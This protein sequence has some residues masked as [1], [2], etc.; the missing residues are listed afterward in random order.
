MAAKSL[1]VEFDERKIDAIFSQVDQCHK[2]GAAVGIAIDGKP[3]Y[4][5]GFGLANMELPIVLSPSIRM[6]IYSMTKHFA[7]LA[8]M[9]LCEDGKAG[10]DDAIGKHVVGL[11]PAS[12]NATVLQLMGHTS[13]IRDAN[14][15]CWQFNGT[16]LPA[17]SAD[18]VALYRDINDV[19]TPAG[20][21]WIYNIGGYLLLTAAIE[22]IAGKRFE[23]VLRE[24]I[25]EP[26]GMFNTMLRRRDID[27]I[28]NSAT[29]HM[30]TM[31][32]AYVKSY[33]GNMAGEG[34]I[35]STVDDMLR[36]LKHMDAPVVGTAETWKLMKAPHV[37]ANGTSTG[38]GLGLWA[39]KYRGA[40]QVRHGGVGMGANSQMIKLPGAALDIVVMVNGHDLSAFTFGNHIIDACVSGLEPVKEE[41][42][43][44]LL[45]GVYVSKKTG[46]VVRLSPAER[47]T[48]VIKEGQQIATVDGIDIP[49]VISDDG[50]LHPTA[51]L[52]PSSR[53]LVTPMGGG[54][55]PGSLRLNEF[56]NIDEFVRQKASVQPDP[57][58]FAGRYAH[59]AT[60]TEA[61]IYDT[62]NSVRLKT[63]GRFGATELELECLAEGYWR[64]KA[65]T[66]MPWGGTLSF[67][68]NGRS[69]LYHSD[70]T[71]GLRF[72]RC[73]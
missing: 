41:V 68:S 3:V 17:T 67:D 63:A 56:G 33:L 29:M 34:G 24:R 44:K 59:P 57:R 50:N 20:T 39:G 51:L 64:A 16:G 12:Q 43:G 18:L 10:L 15:I 58:N 11:N 49:V 23:D 66:P 32:G 25:F 14:D 52:G 55:E 8:Y 62:D 6:R 4:R 73:G 60:G 27:F 5:K 40:D 37:L 36:W 65:T 70:R 31:D 72:L 22:Q 21:T 13:G 54:T 35:V 48:P 45:T 26:V 71:V 61:T 46:R 38:Y 1:A 2:P 19:N 28:P 53:L 9:L 30:T 69:F 47:A 42:K 7:C